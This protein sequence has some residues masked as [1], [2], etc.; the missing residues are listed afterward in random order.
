MAMS[1]S[2]PVFG[3]APS[4]KTPTPQQLQEMY[5]APQR[6]TLDAIVNR[7]AMLLGVL[8]LAGAGAWVLDAG[9]GLIGLAGIVG[10]GLA[11]VNI[12]KRQ[13]T[14]ALVVAYAVC[15]GVFLGGI[16]KVF[17]ESGTYSG[18]PLQAAVGT[19]AIFSGVLWGYK[20]G[21]LRA[22]PR[23]TKIVVGGFVGMFA[24]ILLNALLSWLGVADLGIRH[25][26]GIGVLF[27]IG[28][29]IFGSLTFVLDF[30]QAER[31]IAAGV[32]ERESWRIAFGLVVG[33]VWLYMEILRLLSY[34]R[35]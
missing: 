15:E 32:P 26:G 29:I 10:F 25:A 31:M 5:D 34:F 2:N 20:S 4:L 21:R 35:D 3:N 22:T 24:L 18:L 11:L 8:I 7:T 19:A 27:S 33:L 28:F 12:F 6:L 1:S 30:D 14:P 9:P 17:E 13:I 16:S 23:F